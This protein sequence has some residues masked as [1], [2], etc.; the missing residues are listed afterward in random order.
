MTAEAA[1]LVKVRL[2]SD[3]VTGDGVVQ[4]QGSV[5]EVP[6]T[7]ARALIQDYQAVPV[8]DSDFE[9]EVREPAEAMDTPPVRRRGRPPKVQK[10]NQKESD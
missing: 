2:N 9:R 7:E 8:R 10:E 5:I 6:R 1:E 3:R 4:P